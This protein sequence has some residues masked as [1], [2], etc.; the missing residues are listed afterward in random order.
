MGFLTDVS[1]RVSSLFLPPYRTPPFRSAFAD[2]PDAPRLERPR[3]TSSI[4]RFYQADVEDA[5]A[6]C[7][8]GE[9][10]LAAQLCRALRRDGILGGVLSTRTGGL[11]RLP[12]LFR[13]TPRVVDQLENR[14]GEVGLF[15]KIFPPSELQLFA[16]DG[17][18]LGVAL[19][20][21]ISLPDRLE[22]KF[23]RLN[24]EWIRYSWG[25]NRWYYYS[26][27][28]PIHIVPGDSRW[29]M[30]MPGGLQNPW[31]NGQW[32]ALSRAYVAK[33]S[34]FHCREAYS[35]SLANPAR[36]AYSPQGATEEIK[37]QLFQKLMAWGLNST[38]AMPPGWDVKLL[39]LA[40]GQ[41]HKVFQ[42]TIDA[43]NDEFV[44]CLAGQRV[45]TDGGAGFSNAD[46]HAAIRADLI[47]NDGD[48]LSSCIN[49]QALRQIVNRMFG[50]G[51]RGSFSWDTKPP[52]NLK[53]EAEAVIAAM[54]G[55]A[56]FNQQG[57]PYGLQANMGE[58]ATR[59][60][61]P[62]V[63]TQPKALPAP[64]PLP[65]VAGKGPA[66]SASRARDPLHQR[67]TG[68][69]RSPPPWRAY[70]VPLR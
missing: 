13:G 19:G 26:V 48:G 39:E 61:I 18:L 31:E 3:P 50:A 10:A 30:W 21:L 17:I 11:T 2:S 36:V 69:T 54:E 12:K 20:E 63:F 8:T 9:L 41:G 14:D 45:T 7:D 33:D 28:G 32:S 34:A 35:L 29:V 6:A 42:D 22:P 5:I 49:E 55:I 52:A 15:D 44:V 27:G 65:D 24:P 53:G 51:E 47:Q 25:D 23:V 67:G 40:N 60:R 56:A 4:Q 68:T 58:V 66:I 59:Y 62:S 70:P 57:L 38:F 37:Q 16:G 64:Q 1:K 46:V 43:S